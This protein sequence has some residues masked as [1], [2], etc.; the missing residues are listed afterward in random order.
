MVTIKDKSWNDLKRL[1]R[2]LQQQMWIERCVVWKKDHS[3]LQRTSFTTVQRSL[4]D[5]ECQL[6][7]AELDGVRGHPIC[8]A[9][10]AMPILDWITP[11][12]TEWGSEMNGASGRWCGSGNSGVTMSWCERPY[13][14]SMERST[15]ASAKR[16]L[17]YIAWCS[18]WNRNSNTAE[19]I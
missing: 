4:L 16:M 9:C 6:P 17:L 18:A 11:P 10:V 7:Y 2:T 5:K 15:T 1:I 14:L 12:A 13:R 8:I 3:L 19:R